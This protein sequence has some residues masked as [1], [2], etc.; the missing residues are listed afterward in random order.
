MWFSLQIHL[1]CK[2]MYFTMRKRQTLQNR[3]LYKHIH[4]HTTL[5]HLV[6]YGYRFFK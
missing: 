1:I 5:D 6:W 3:E 2:E 4:V